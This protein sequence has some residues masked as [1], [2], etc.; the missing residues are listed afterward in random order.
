MIVISRYSLENWDVVSDNMPKRMI[1]NTVSLRETRERER[2][3]HNSLCLVSSVA[4]DLSCFLF[5]NTHL[6]NS[7]SSSSS[8]S[9]SLH[10]WQAFR[11][12]SYEFSVTQLFG[13]CFFCSGFSTTAFVVLSLSLSLS[14]SL[15]FVAAALHL[16]FVLPFFVG[17]VLFCGY[18]SV[19]KK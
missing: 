14:G 6:L 10:Q 15:S 16:F 12:P 5:C 17:F 7:S 1:L 11:A 4:M 19:V 2:K 13:C 3:E 9:L 18:S 8:L